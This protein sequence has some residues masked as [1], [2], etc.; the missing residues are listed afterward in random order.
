MSADLQVIR[1]DVV[2]VGGGGAGLRA[3]IAAHQAD[4][5][6]AVALLSKVVPMRSHTV[7]AEGGSAGVIRDGRLAGAALRGHRLRRRLAVRPGR[8][9]VLRRALRRRDGAARAL[10][11][12]LE[13]P[14]RR[15]HQRALLRRHEGAAHLVRR[16]QDRLSPAAHPVPDLAALR[17]HPTLRRVLRRRPGG[18]GR[19]RPR[20]AGD[21]DRQRRA[22]P[23]R[24]PGR[25]P[26]HRRGRA[27]VPAQ[28]QR[29]HRHRRRHGDG[30]PATAWRCAT[31]SSCSTTPP[32][33]RAA[34]S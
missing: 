28:H 30:L 12:P 8:G 18:G 21:R 5:G 2:I 26:V 3:A 24:G 14:R 33:C 11:L 15:P 23:L 6:L 4:P 9:A 22:L 16:R 13:P 10:G 7:A 29:R 1:A 31:W 19:A 34:A 17:R 32:R 27:R 20:R 25:D